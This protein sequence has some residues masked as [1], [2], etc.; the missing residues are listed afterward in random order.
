MIL[1][2]L[3]PAAENR[4]G[5]KNMKTTLRQLAMAGAL[6]ACLAPA[7]LARD[8]RI[9]VDGRPVNL[10]S[11]H[12]AYLNRGV[13]MIPA[14]PVLS[15]ARVWNQW[16]SRDRELEIRT[17]RDSMFV[18]VDSHTV[19][20]RGA[21]RETLSRP[22]AMH[23][24]EPYVPVQLLETC[25]DRRA[26]YDRRN[27]VLSFGSSWRDRRWDDRGPRDGGWGNRDRA[28]RRDDGLRPDDRRRI[29]L[30]LEVPRRGSGRSVRVYGQ[31]G[32][33]S[34]RIRV[35]RSDGR[36]CVNRTVGVRDGEWFITLSLSGDDYR[37]VAEG[38]FDRSVRE[39]REARF[40]TR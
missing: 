40:S 15:A 23:H 25:L 13:W 37:I 10:G 38:Y 17:F 27:E 29:P 32:G 35:Y 30:T 11:R 7:A 26:D 16:N 31:W 5:A 19:Q 14:R 8:L 4:P 18:T 34:V 28:D 6:S 3:W 9:E 24:G 39:S 2:T 33:T 21:R 12:Q 1:D 36:E 22:V 20:Y